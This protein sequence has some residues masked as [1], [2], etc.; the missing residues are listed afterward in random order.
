M[1]ASKEQRETSVERIYLEEQ[2]RAF[3][4]AKYLIAQYRDISPDH[5][6]CS[7]LLVIVGDIISDLRLLAASFG[8]AVLTDTKSQ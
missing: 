5:I 7:N 8:D 6:D 4:R 2:Q 1:E 3:D